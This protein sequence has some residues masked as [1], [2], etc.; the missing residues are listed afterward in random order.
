[1]NAGDLTAKISIDKLEENEVKKICKDL[2]VI[3]FDL[4]AWD[5]PHSFKLIPLKEEEE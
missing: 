2:P 4:Y 1:M 5:R 3:L